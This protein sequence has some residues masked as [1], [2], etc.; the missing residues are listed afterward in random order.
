MKNCIAV[1][2]FLLTFTLSAFAQTTTKTFTKGFNADG[3]TRISFDLPGPIDLK[4]WNK[5]TIRMEIIVGLP[6]G[7]VSIV[8]Q[9]AKVGRYDLKADADGE[10]LLITAPNLSKV[11]TVKGQELNEQVSYVIFIPKDL[12]V[13]LRS[14]PAVATI[15]QK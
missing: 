3:K 6:S 15:E 8:D 13:V 1:L 11:V 2:A 5:S 4:I 7:N 14:P 12:E 9:L 10:T